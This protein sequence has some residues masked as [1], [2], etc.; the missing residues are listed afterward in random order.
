MVTYSA[1]EGRS[2]EDAIIITD[3]DDHFEGID[4]EYRYIENE[5]G[6]RGVEWQLIKQEL[7]N[8]KQQVYDRIIIQLTD[9]S[10]VNLYFNLTA[11]FGKG[12]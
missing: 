12:F 1:N 2:I 4:A 5:F 6:R 3:V 10:V 7:L 11:F 9:Q 8:E